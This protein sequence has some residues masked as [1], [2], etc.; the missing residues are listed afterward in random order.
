MRTSDRCVIWKCQCDCGKIVYVSAKSLKQSNT[1]SCG[2]LN[3]ETRAALGKTH[4]K[5]LTGQIFGKLTVL[6]DF[7][8]RKDNAILWKCK[9]A[10]G[11]I[12]Y[13]KGISLKTGHTTS[14]GCIVSKGEEK[15][16]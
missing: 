9:C 10:C 5:D 2:C 4:K 1:K 3:T 13:V 15:I 12:I 11:A 16:S 6:G 14:C 8:D 7:G